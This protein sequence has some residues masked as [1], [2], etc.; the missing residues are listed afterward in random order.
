MLTAGDLRHRII[1]QKMEQKQD[2][3]GGMISKWVTHQGLWAHIKAVSA[4]EFLDG[5]RLEEKI[6]HKVR[7]RFNQTIDAS[8][9][10]LFSGE[11]LQIKGILHDYEHKNETLILADKGPPT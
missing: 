1:V 10:I 4:G 3:L 9:R 2:D 11:I 8:M 7:I 6:S 5:Q